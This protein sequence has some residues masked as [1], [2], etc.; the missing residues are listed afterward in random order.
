MTKTQVS[1]TLLRLG[2]ASDTVTIMVDGIPFSG[3]R[4][5][6]SSPSILPPQLWRRSRLFA[7]GGCRVHSTKGDKLERKV[8]VELMGRI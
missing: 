4:E 5:P 3:N 1:R 8:Q 6:S 2:D 7:L